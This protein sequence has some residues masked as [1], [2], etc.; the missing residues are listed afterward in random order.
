MAGRFSAGRLGGY[1]RIA[2]CGES[3]TRMPGKP[4]KNAGVS[5]TARAGGWWT[6]LKG[7]VLAKEV[8]AQVTTLISPNA[9]PAMIN[10]PS[11]C[12]FW[13]RNMKFLFLILLSACILPAGQFVRTDNPRSGVWVTETG[14]RWLWVVRNTDEVR[15]LCEGYDGCVRWTE[16]QTVGEIIGVDSNKVWEHECAHAYGFSL[17]LTPAQVTAEVNHLRGM[18]AWVNIW[19]DGPARGEPC[20]SS[21]WSDGTVAGRLKTLEQSEH[22]RKP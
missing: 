4:D 7:I 15:L 2:P 16:G 18:P 17:G 1:E 22:E 20:G 12:E 11:P 14:Y 21:T 5:A 9:I 10:R 6:V 19:L 3:R 13:R 8:T